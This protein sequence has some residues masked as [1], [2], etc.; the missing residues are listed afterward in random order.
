MINDALRMIRVFHG[1]NARDLAKKLDVSASYIS[2]IERRKKRPTL[3]LVETYAR[4]FEL[5][6]S[7]IVYFGEALQERKKG[8][9]CIHSPYAQEKLKTFLWYVERFDPD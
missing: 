4:K 2:Q 7:T 6:V 9:R 3:K 5:T 1:L 8:V